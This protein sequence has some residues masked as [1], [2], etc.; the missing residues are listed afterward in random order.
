MKTDQ[1]NYEK[2]KSIQTFVIFLIIALSLLAM[3]S[4]PALNVHHTPQLTIAGSPSIIIILIGFGIGCYGTIV[5]IGGGPLILPT[6]FFYYGWSNEFLVATSLF[7]VFLNAASGSIAYARQ[8]RIEYK[9]ALKFS[10]AALPGAVLSGFVHHFFNINIFDHIFGIFLILLAFYSLANLNKIGSDVQ[11]K[12]NDKMSAYR[13]VSMKDRFGQRFEFYSHD[14]LG[15]TLNLGLGFFVGFLGI[16]GGV[17]QMPILLFLLHYP[18]HIST[19][20]SHMITM[21]TC[22]FALIPHIF[23]GNIFYAEAMWMGLG[24]IAG[25]QLGAFLAPKIKSKVLIYLFIAILLTFA[26]KLLV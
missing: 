10:L 6:L 8:K 14:K 3:F 5:G 16:G 12:N 11:K 13:F 25:A 23:L 19:A 17:L 4:G 22:F 18:A 24:V 21:L 9:A 26:F 20:T 15:I 1:G 7:I 2:R